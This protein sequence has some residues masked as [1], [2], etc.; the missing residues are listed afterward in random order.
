MTLGSLIYTIQK[1]K[2]ECMTDITK[3]IKNIRISMGLTQ[4]GLS[5]ELGISHQLVNQ[6]ESGRCKPGA[7]TILKLEKFSQKNKIPFN[8]E[9]FF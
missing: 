4:A 9:D 5:R 1:N 8:R 7:A 6:W 3:I 2:E